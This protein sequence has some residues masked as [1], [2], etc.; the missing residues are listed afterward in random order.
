MRPIATDIVMLHGLC[1]TV[2]ST[3]TN[4][5]KM[6]RQSRCRLGERVDSCRPKEPH[7]RWRCKLAPP[8]KYD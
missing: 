8:G 4:P 1:V 6:V 7:I 2:L 5:G 3:Q